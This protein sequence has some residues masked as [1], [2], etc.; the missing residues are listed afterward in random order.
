M[1]QVSFENQ[2]CLIVKNCTDTDFCKYTVKTEDEKEEY[3]T[4]LTKSLS[5]QEYLDK[6]DNKMFLSGMLDQE[7]TQSG[8]CQFSVILMNSF[9]EVNWMK[10]GQPLTGGDFEEKSN[11]NER[12]L[13]VKNCKDSAEY[14]VNC[15]NEKMSAKLKVNG[16]SEPAVPEPAALKP[17]AAN[18]QTSATASPTKTEE[19]K[20]QASA[21]TATKPPAEK[22]E[23]PEHVPDAPIERMTV[24]EVIEGGPWKKDD[25]GHWRSTT[26]IKRLKFKSLPD[27]L[28]RAETIGTKWSYDGARWAPIPV[29]V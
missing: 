10:D 5:R 25:E 18:E 13:F 26:I 1:E 3:S 27:P 29:T 16:S 24:R 28:L 2:R 15:G 21:P 12:T 22:A 8:N 23:E 9:A 17:V 7:I 11:G 4:Y 19:S 20:P 14:S 6:I